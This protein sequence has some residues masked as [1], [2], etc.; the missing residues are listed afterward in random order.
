MKA[1]EFEDAIYFYKN[2]LSAAQISKTVLRPFIDNS[3]FISELRYRNINALLS[4]P[5]GGL[6][7]ILDDSTDYFFKSNISTCF[8]ALL[9]NVKR[10]NRDQRVALKSLVD[11]EKVLRRFFKI[12]TE[13]QRH[14]ANY[15]GAGDNYV[16][17]LNF[18][19]FPGTSYY[20]EEEIV[21]PVKTRPAADLSVLPDTVR[22]KTCLNYDFRE[23]LSDLVEI[24][25]D[26][27]LFNGKIKVSAVDNAEIR[28]GDYDAVLV[29]VSG[30]RSNFLFDLYAIFLREPD[31][32]A[33]KIN[34]ATGVD[35]KSGKPVID[36]RSFEEGRNF[37]RLDLSRESV[38]SE[39]IK[40]LLNDVWGFMSTHEIGDKQAYA[41]FLDELE[42]RMA[43]GSWLFSLPSLAYFSTQFDANSID[44]YGTASQL[45]TIE[46]W[47]EQKK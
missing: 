45:S 10:L 32:S 22:V 38:E 9:Y 31:F 14:I 30:Y 1:G 8:F 4:T 37:F 3:T 26:P 42:A 17:Y 20:I 15:K 39:D 25:N 5:F 2:P 24:F 19:V 6:S 44:L 34:L 33:Y 11:N 28:R 35:A 23:E 18:S 12:G 21:A 41:R 46:K 43:L 7:P 40:A 47:Q 36:P 16:D 13:Q 27:S 29:P